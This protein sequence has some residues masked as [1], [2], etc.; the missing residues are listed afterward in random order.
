M[1]NNILMK[2]A[3]I[4]FVIDRNGSRFEVKGPKE[5]LL[6]LQLTGCDEYGM[7]N[8]YKEWGVLCSVTKEFIRLDELLYWDQ[9]KQLPFKN[10]LVVF[11]YAKE[12]KFFK[13]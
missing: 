12:H 8:A 13:H 1:E 6:D 11:E 10:A 9:E 2:L 7:I 5:L 3:E 4:E